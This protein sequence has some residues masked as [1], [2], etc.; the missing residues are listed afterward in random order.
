[1]SYREQ[2]MARV[3]GQAQ[4]PEPDWEEIAKVSRVW[5]PDDETVGWA[6]LQGEDRLAWISA[7]GPDKLGY[8]IRNRIDALMVDG[9]RDGVPALSTWEEILATTLHTVPTNKYLPVFLADV[10]KKWSV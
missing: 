9:P 1:M 5:V 8:D 4:Y 3:G 7:S 6:V 2:P 10:H